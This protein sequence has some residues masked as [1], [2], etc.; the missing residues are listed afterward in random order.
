MA[1][2]PDARARTARD[3]DCTAR[4]RAHR[5]GDGDGD[6]SARDDPARD[7]PA[8]DD[9]ARDAPARDRLA[10]LAVVLGVLAISLLELQLGGGFGD[11][12]Q[13]TRDPGALAC[14]LVLLSALALLWRRSHPQA[15]V[16]A[17]LALSLLL[18]ALSYGLHA[19]PAPAV[20]LYAVAVAPRPGRAWPL[21][22]VAAVA[23]AALV[24]IELALTP[25]GVADYALPGLV[26]AGAWLVGDRRRFLRAQ[27]AERLDRARREQQLAVAEERARI[28]RELHDSAGHAL[29]TILVQAGA[30]RV[31]RERDAERSAEAVATVEQLARETIEEIDRIV[32]LL[33]DE[34]EPDRAPLPGIDQ[35]PALVERQRAGGLDV[36][37]TVT[38]AS[39]APAAPAA[40][41]A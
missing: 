35:L 37:L 19:P 39:P 27:L 4:D 22:L 33:R 2:P 15:V 3:R 24:L 20:A 32:G 41:A 13:E 34:Q 8:R 26:W 31:L 23:W 25:Y 7:D 12:A 11:F 10:D 5:D 38:G 18:A 9:P 30:A 29:N 36:E 17:T 28:A 14:A 21:L 40:P 6:R 16:L 1:T